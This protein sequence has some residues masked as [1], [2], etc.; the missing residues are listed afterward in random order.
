MKKSNFEYQKTNLN[1]IQ[2]TKKNSQAILPKTNLNIIQNISHITQQKTNNIPKTR[3]IVLFPL[4][5]GDKLIRH[6][7]AATS[8]WDN[9]HY[10]YTNGESQV[11]AVIDQSTYE[12]VKLFFNSRPKN[13]DSSKS[14]I[15][16]HKSILKTFIARP[17]VKSNINRARIT[18]YKYNRQKVYYMNMLKKSFTLWPSKT[19]KKPSVNL[20]LNSPSNKVVTTVNPSLN[21][22]VKGIKKSVFLPLA[23]DKKGIRYYNTYAVP[24]AFRDLKKINVKYL[25]QKVI[26]PSEI[27]LSIRKV[28]SL[29]R[30][31]NMT[32][33]AMKNNNLSIIQSEK[34]SMSRAPTLVITRSDSQEW[35]ENPYNR[36]GVNKLDTNI[37]K[38]RKSVESIKRK[39]SKS[40]ILYQ[41]SSKNNQIILTEVRKGHKKYTDSKNIPKFG[42]L[43]FNK[44]V[45]GKFKKVNKGINLFIPTL[46]STN[47]IRYWY[48]PVVRKSR[49]TL[50]KKRKTTPN[51]VNIGRVIQ[52]RNK[53]L[54]TIQS[55]KPISLFLLRM[56]KIRMLKREKSILLNIL[57]NKTF[58]LVLST[59]KNSYKSKSSILVLKR[60]ENYSLNF[61]L[62]VKSLKLF[63]FNFGNMGNYDC[64]PSF[65]LTIWNKLINTSNPVLPT[66]PLAKKGAKQ[67]ANLYNKITI[68]S[69]RLGKFVGKIY[70][71]I[72][73]SKFYYT[74]LWVYYMK[75][76]N[77][78][79]SRLNN[80]LKKRYG[81]KISLNIVDLKYLYLDSNIMASAITTK[82]KDRKKRVLRV[83]KRALGLIKK[84]Y[85]KIH[86]YNRKKTL[87]Q[88]NVNF[89]LM[90]KNLNMSTYSLSKN[91]LNKDLFKKP[92]N[93]KSRLLL[94]HLKH[95]IVSGVRL[96]GSGRLTRRL[97]AS[98]SISK[99]KYMGSLQNIESSRQAVSTVML[100][101][102]MKSN[103]QYMN[104]NSYNRNGAFGVKVSVSSY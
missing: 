11:S 31:S 46:Y 39:Q 80:I 43:P 38:H 104:I 16:N 78:Y 55:R 15:F 66:F 88:L 19:L 23:K 58:N 56:L 65:L 4:Q 92:S 13:I 71:R 34:K 85:F 5:Y 36:Y 57:R 73:A 26:K 102:Y 28:L 95:K 89:L 14:S 21:Y 61:Y 7:P 30:H 20:R 86:F 76:N 25:S 84:P 33:S 8:E 83:L 79:L 59:L 98:R 70:K 18:I 101:G 42:K 48:L 87:E 69:L 64:A 54:N 44:K 97:T 27:K 81:K 99:F 45:P 2:N 53:G 52:K 24:F 32:L 47:Q 40:N 74:I 100:R 1:T 91:I 103:L 10:S 62:K 41:F 51:T 49:I 93:Y 12:L 75:S 17:H 68:P 77:I 72:F 94:F 3:D 63:L 9:S 35:L 96:Q 29:S 22:L 60:I 50:S 82:L 90:D 67:N 37:Q 6:N